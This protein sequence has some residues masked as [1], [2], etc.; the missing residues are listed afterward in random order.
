MSA[1]AADDIAANL[2]TETEFEALTEGTAQIPGRD[3][4]DHGAAGESDQRWRADRDAA[5]SAE[6]RGSVQEAVG[7]LIRDLDAVKAQGFGAP[8]VPAYLPIGHAEV[9]CGP[10]LHDRDSRAATAANRGADQNSML[11]STP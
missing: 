2:G 11:R 3:G 8:G 5:C 4:H 6:R 1:V 9:G 10:D 7:N